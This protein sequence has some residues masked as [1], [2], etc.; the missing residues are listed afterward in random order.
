MKKLNKLINSYISKGYTVEQAL[1]KIN[2]EL[3][4]E[5]TRYCH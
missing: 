1:E 4:V 3:F 5:N 2:L